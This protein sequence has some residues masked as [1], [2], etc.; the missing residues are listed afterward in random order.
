MSDDVEFWPEKDASGNSLR[1]VSIAALHSELI[2]VTASGQLHQWKW[3]DTEPY[4][5][6]DV[7]F[8]VLLYHLPYSS[9]IGIFFTTPN[10]TVECKKLIIIIFVGRSLPS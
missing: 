9:L 8:A 10:H 4:R 1:F 5:H 7:S 6:P 2:A 3:S